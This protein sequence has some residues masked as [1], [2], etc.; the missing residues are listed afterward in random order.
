M[1]IAQEVKKMIDNNWC[2]D[3][4]AHLQDCIKMGKCQG[5]EITKDA[6]DSV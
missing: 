4:S 3:C 2:F 5:G 1:K 6:K